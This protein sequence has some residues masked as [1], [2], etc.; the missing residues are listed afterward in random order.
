MRSR[1]SASGQFRSYSGRGS[2]V[3]VVQNAHGA[4]RVIQVTK[5]VNEARDRASAIEEDYK[6]LRAAM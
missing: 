3:V 6:T 1:G 5:A 4:K 2:S